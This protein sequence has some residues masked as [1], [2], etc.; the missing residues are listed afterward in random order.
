MTSRGAT[1]DCAHYEL[2]E[3]GSSRL[4][5]L[6]AS[7]RAS[8]W[9]YRLKRCSTIYGI[10][11]VKIPSML[12]AAFRAL[13]HTNKPHSIVRAGVLGCHNEFLSL[14]LQSTTLSRTRAGITPDSQKI[15]WG[16]FLPPSSS[17][18]T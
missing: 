3:A 18:L 5:P 12:R 14:H 1:A 11:G 16:F 15:C 6:P 8:N 17:N 10:I 9:V 4:A 2:A 7:P 13:T